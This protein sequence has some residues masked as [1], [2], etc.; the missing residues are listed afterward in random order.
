MNAVVK[1]KFAV[2]P[3]VAA[4]ALAFSAVNAYADPTPIAQ[5]GQGL[6][7]T[8]ACAPIPEE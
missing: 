7:L 2:K 3:V 6:V 8:S 1:T 5:P 4:L